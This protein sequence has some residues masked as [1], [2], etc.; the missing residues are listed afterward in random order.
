M[1]EPDQIWI[2]RTASGNLHG[3]YYVGAESEEKAR[4]IIAGILPS[5]QIIGAKQ[6]RNVEHVRRHE[7]RTVPIGNYWG[8]LIPDYA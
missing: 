8:P 4:Q 3:W 1:T 5:E 7:I 6:V 2:V